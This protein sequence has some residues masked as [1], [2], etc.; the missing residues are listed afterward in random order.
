MKKKKLQ[1]TN[2][3]VAWICPAAAVELLPS[4]LMLDEEHDTPTY[5]TAYDDNVYV[6]GAM[7]GHNVVIATCPQGMTGNVNAGRLA[8][9]LFNTFSKVRMAL[10]VGIGGGVP[11]SVPSETSTDNIHVGD[12]VVGAPGDGKPA[13]INY[14]SGRSHHGGTFE[15]LG[16]IDR[17]DRVLL[18]AIEKLQ[19]DYDV[20]Q[21]TFQQ[22]REKLEKSRHRRRFAFPGLVHDRLFQADY[23]HVGPYNS[24]CI[25]CDHTRLVERPART[26][27]DAAE[28]IF[29][30][31]RIA[32]GNSVVQD[33]EKRDRIREL[34]DGALCIEMEAAGVDASRPCLVIRG[35][36]DYADSHKE[37]KWRSYAAGN[38]AIFARE[39]LSK[40]PPWTIVERSSEVQ[41]HYFMVPFGRNENFIGR[42]SI[43]DEVLS[44]IP[45]EANKDDCQ[46]TA[47]EG[48]GGIGKTQIAL[49][50]AYRFRE[51]Y[52]NCSIF[53]VPAIDT[54][55]FE[56]AY[57]SIGLK[58][59][60]KKVNDDNV[61]VKMLVKTALSHEDVGN[62]LLIIDSADDLKLQFADTT[63]S[64]Y[65]PFNRKGSILF[66]TR[67]HKA[68]IDLDIPPKD[69]MAISGMTD[70]EAMDLLRTGLKENQTRDEKNMKLL[71]EFL[72]NLPLAIKQASSYMASNTNV[73]VSEY[74]DFCQS[75]DD[76]IDLLSRD[77]EDRHRY[78]SIAKQQNPIAK[79]WL[80]SFQRISQHNPQAT[81]YLK[82]LCLL[83]EKDIPLSLLPKVSK[84]K[85]SEAIGTL[86]AYSFIM[87]RKEPD[88]YDMHRLVRLAMR[89]WL[90]AN[91]E[92]QDWTTKMTQQVAK[93]YPIPEH[94]NKG[95]WLRYLPH[96]QAILEL[97]EKSTD[98]YPILLIGMACAYTL[99][100][101]YNEA[102][103]IYRQVLEIR[104]QVLGKEHPDT[105]DIL[106]RL[107]QVLCKLGKYEMAVQ[108]L[109][110]TIEAMSERLGREHQSTL[111]SMGVLVDA[112]L[113]QEK[114]E[115]AE[116]ITRQILELRNQMLGG[117]HPDTLGSM[118]D[119]A[120]ILHSQQNYKE[121]EQMYRQ[122]L[123]LQSRV[124]GGDH[125][126]TLSS[127]HNLAANLEK[128][129]NHKEAEQMYRQVLEL[130]GRVLGE[131]HP[132]TLS[133]MNN[134]AVL[135]HDQG[136][137]R[138]AEQICRL[139]LELQ[140]QTLGREHP[141]TL[142]CMN[143]LASFIQSQGNYK[144]AEQMFRQ[145]LELQSRV[146]GRAHPDISA[147]MGNLYKN[148]ER[149]GIDGEELFERLRTFFKTLWP[150]DIR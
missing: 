133:S 64:E 136:N 70:N 35:I 147:C 22:H 69:I 65:L 55:S 100:G 14:E 131:E 79:T 39:L 7:V 110:Q 44:K 120:T 26:K 114:L 77:F 139:T 12:V 42:E 84:L 20:D 126:E 142:R 150:E 149:Q 68:V 73:T 52:P 127:M 83:A 121:A 23:Q 103:R 50:T 3:H 113:G 57:R 63:L 8:G 148:L 41:H 80:I 115:E 25:D 86:I 30:R 134:L 5:D 74:L 125:P 104:E 24:N 82:S 92:W 72:A 16:T 58:L 4:R 11:R 129:K 97:Q 112:F 140:S 67:N 117:E 95:I 18:S 29:H 21:S 118:H 101:K 145:V 49:E 37:D 135:L 1:R 102:E 2:Y 38:A 27:Q 61:D 34:C 45:P 66:T 105:L 123:E 28:F 96:G 54:S 40:V 78:G 48:L 109:Q 141:E 137:S 93:E 6:F 13:C 128:Q 90:Q 19:S 31:G 146:L 71:L 132:Y 60:L 43:L 89:N 143:N 107:G 106:P 59:G 17:P 81:E 111:F 36:S 91:G 15:L 119:L 47:I 85:A 46:R 144:E 76:M 94:H 130:K 56:N 75:N 51:Q 98:L 32:S 124:L 33:G 88:S 62:W 116:Q 138:E 122:T 10:L 9:P 53:W 99:L 87:E 108:M